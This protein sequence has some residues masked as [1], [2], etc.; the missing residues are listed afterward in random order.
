MASTMDAPPPPLVTPARVT[1]A[2]AYAEHRRG[3]VA[4]CV[5]ELGGPAVGMHRTS[6]FQAAS[7]VKAML[8]VAALRR[9]Q[10]RRLSLAERA[11]L[12]PMIRLSENG[13]AEATFHVV[14]TGGLRAVA[15]AAGMRRFRVQDG[16]LFEARVT[17]SDQAR[18]FLAL[19]DLVPRSHR[20]YARA[21]LR[22][23]VAPQRW[24]IPRAAAPRG[25]RVYFKGG[26]RAKLV[27][28]AALLERGGRRLSVAVMTDHDPSMAYGVQTIE[29]VT[30][31]L[32]G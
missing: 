20:G 22:T 8:L 31:R 2:R 18:L 12:G 25:F 4:F 13:A 23:V 10:G 26:W 28:Q 19:D 27:V 9:A 17:A 16:R 1:A 14:G 30:R 21:L 5:R 24:G 6:A 3:K 32:L 29:G 7:V 15:R 11:S